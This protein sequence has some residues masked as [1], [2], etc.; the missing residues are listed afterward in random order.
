MSTLGPDFPP[1]HLARP[2]EG[3]GKNRDLVAERQPVTDNGVMRLAALSPA[4]V[5][6]AFCAGCPPAPF[7]PG[8]VDAG[9]PG[10][11]VLAADIGT[12]CTY[13]PAIGDNPTNQCAPGTEC[14]I[15]TQDGR[16]NTLAL[17]LPFWEDQLTVAVGDTDIGYC[18]VVGN[19]VV[20]AVCPVGTIRKFMTSP[21]APGGFASLCL[22]PCS[23]SAEC[24][25][26]RVCDVRFADPG[27]TDGIPFC[28][29]PCRADLSHCVR[30]AVITID[31]GGAAATALFDSDLFG[32]AVCN[33]QTGLCAG[34]TKNA[35]GS[36]GAQCNSAADCASGLACYQPQLFG[37]PPEFGFCA[38]RC[39]IDQQEGGRPEQGTCD[40]GEGCQPGLAFGYNPTAQFRGMLAFDAFNNLQTQEGFCLDICTEGVTECVTG[41]LCG[42]TDAQV[43]A[44]SWIETEMCV[45]P[46][47]RSEG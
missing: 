33:L 40:P 43:I 2:D 45:P 36:A 19:A 23:V 28:V 6:V 25:A 44:Q 9:N 15:V 32:D 29:S 31:E 30:S 47:I 42:A 26:N 7:T 18:T 34:T 39:N 14:V 22:K 8:E 21:A 27:S 5:V 11:T 35:A 13:D 46:A 20:P 41:A 38:S 3:D 24:G 37:D 4:V 1:C 17:S 10:D 16:F 12:P